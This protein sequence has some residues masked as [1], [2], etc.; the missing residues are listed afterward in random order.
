MTQTVIG[1]FDDASEAQT[2]MQELMEAGFS[3]NNIDLSTQ[4]PSDAT[5]SVSSADYRTDADHNHEKKG[6]IMGFFASLFSDDDDDR[7]R[8]STVGERH[9]ILTVHAQSEDE[10]ERAADIL[11]DAGAIDV[12]E[13]AEQ[14][15]SGLTTGV[16]ADPLNP[17]YGDTPHVTS[18]S[19]NYGDT[20]ST[21]RNSSMNAPSGTD[22]NSSTGT[23]QQDMGQNMGDRGN[24]N[25][26][27]IFDRSLDETNRLRDDRSWNNNESMKRPDADVDAENMIN[28]NPGYNRTVD[29]ESDVTKR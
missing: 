21:S 5:A 15:R 3:R 27:R 28:T 14:Y 18:D 24:R 1:I 8:Y 20:D 16:S 19:T 6:G 11:D 29:P 9:S 12:N 26:S 4:T 13:R 2:A 22:W 23:N 17:I 25:R 7:N 10:A